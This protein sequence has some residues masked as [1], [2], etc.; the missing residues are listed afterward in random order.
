M[1]ESGTQQ[2]ILE[3][4]DWYVD[5]ERW[6]RTT[7]RQIVWQQADLTPAVLLGLAA[8]YI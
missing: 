5:D 6:D 4:D 8:S 7:A 3:T 2:A 1:G